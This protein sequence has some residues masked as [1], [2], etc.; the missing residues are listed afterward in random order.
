[1]RCKNKCEFLKANVEKINIFG[2]VVVNK[3]SGKHGRTHSEVYS[4][5]FLF[6]FSDAV[7]THRYF[8]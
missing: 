6:V 1:M 8:Q 3:I 2:P 4:Y 7:F 5:C